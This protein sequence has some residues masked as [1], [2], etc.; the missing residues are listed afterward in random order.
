MNI[1]ILGS[2][3]YIGKKLINYFKTDHNIITS[4]RNSKN[5]ENNV[6]ILFENLESFEILNYLNTYKVDYIFYALNSYYK[7]PSEKE[8]LEMNKVNYYYPLEILEVLNKENIDIKI[9]FFS[10]YFDH[11]TVNIE[12]EE[13]AKSKKKLTQYLKHETSFNNFKSL[14][15]SDT[16]GTWDTRNKIFNLMLKNIVN[17]KK[18]EIKNPDALVNLIHVDDLLVKISDFIFSEKKFE[19]FYNLYSITLNNLK[20]LLYDLYIK[21]SINFDDFFQSETRFDVSNSTYGL[22][23]IDD[24]SSILLNK[25]YI[26]H[27]KK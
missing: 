1:L 23:T 19:S 13:Y 18:L 20:K 11:I 6:D 16:F 10:S 17:N 26:E 8:I 27:L 25:K 12:S 5:L 3:G 2:T 22:N 15:I 7:N 9:L 4:A 14:E 24:I 21:E